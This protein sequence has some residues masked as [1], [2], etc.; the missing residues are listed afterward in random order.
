[1]G[2]EKQFYGGVSYRIQH[3]QNFVLLTGVQTIDNDHQTCLVLGEAV[4]SLGHLSH[5]LHLTFQHLR[6]DLE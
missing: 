4:D 3:L 1:M 2:Y 6:R 5:E